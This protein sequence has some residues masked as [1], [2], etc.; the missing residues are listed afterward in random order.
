MAQKSMASIWKFKM[1]NDL[2]RKQK[3]YDF[4]INVLLQVIQYISNDIY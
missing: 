3:R 4:F 1:K 2:L